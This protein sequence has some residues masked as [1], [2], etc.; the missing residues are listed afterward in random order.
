MKRL[1]NRLYAKGR[2]DVAASLAT[3][4]GS[5]VA[6][7]V[8]DYL[9]ILQTDPTGKAAIAAGAGWVGGKVAFYL[10]TETGPI[11]ATPTPPTLEG[12]RSEV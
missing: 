3:G 1:W 7:V 12:A 10:Q 9:E 11:V 8:I 6:L 2:A 4:G 5:V